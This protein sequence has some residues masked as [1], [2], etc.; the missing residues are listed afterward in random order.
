[1][2]PNQGCNDFDRLQLGSPNLSNSFDMMPDLAALRLGP[3]DGN[4]CWS[5]LGPLDGEYGLSPLQ[6]LV[7][8][9]ML[10]FF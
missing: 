2:I 10:M 4:Y 1:M 9:S 7:K 8:I 6:Q 3:S 5:P